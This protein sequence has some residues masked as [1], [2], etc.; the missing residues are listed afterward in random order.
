[1]EEVPVLAVVG[2]GT[3][4]EAVVSLAIEKGWPRDRF[5]LTH[6]RADRRAELEATLGITVEADNEAAVARADAVLVGVRPQEFTGVLETI[7]PGLNSDQLFISIAAALS[8]SWLEHRLP[9]GMAV[10]RAV[11]PPTSWIRAGYGLLAA[12]ETATNNHRNAAER[13]FINTCAELRWLPDELIDAATAIGPALTPYT[14]MMVDAAVRAGTE[15]GIPVDLAQDLA[16]AGVEAAGR[17]ILSS[18]Y[19][20]TDIIRMVATREGLTWASLNTMKRD[21]FPQATRAGVRAMVARSIELRGEP[22]P[23]DMGGFER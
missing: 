18:G 21:G 15:L 23:A 8:I 20:T 3:M 16:Q 22:M 13:L 4:A 17:M 6:R 5:I 7:R 19:S 1:M 14:C 11:P 9:E 10:V 2:V 12:N